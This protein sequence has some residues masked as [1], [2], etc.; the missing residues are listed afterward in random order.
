M[1][2]IAPQL[3]TLTDGMNL[4]TAGCSQISEAMGALGDGIKQAGELLGQVEE[5]R[6]QMRDAMQTLD[7]EISKFKTGERA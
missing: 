5:G 6:S 2:S 4:Q 7:S 3:E 1:Q